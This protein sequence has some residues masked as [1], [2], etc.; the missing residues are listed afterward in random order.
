[1]NIAVGISGGVDSAVAA[2]ICKN[3]GHNVIGVIMK[4][5][6]ENS[7]YGDIDPTRHACYGPEEK[8]D[9]EDAVR[10]CKT[11]DIPLHIIDCVDAFSQKIL[12][13]FKKTYR[14][15]LTP[16]PCIFC[17]QQLK[18]GLL[19]ELLQE[20]QLPI[21][22]FATGHYARV[23]QSADGSV[24][25]LRASDKTKDQSYFLHRLT[26][27]QLSRTLF[28]L[29]ELSKMQVREIARSN[30]LHV[31]GKTESQD[32]YSGDYRNILKD[33]NETSFG[34]NIVDIEGNVLG[35]HDGIWNYTIGQRKGLG[36]AAGKP[37]YVIDIDPDKRSV[38]VGEKNLL[39]KTRVTLS[40]FHQ[41]EQLKPDLTCKIRSSSHMLDCHVIYD[42]SSNV[43]IEFDF[44][45]TGI[46]P[47]QSLVLYDND[48]VIGGGII[49]EGK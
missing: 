19:P 42:N 9:I 27:D 24:H 31:W 5:W 41:L 13:Y 16:N 10:V 48:I 4:I 23:Q 22:Y 25:L 14:Q 47:G 49:Q 6:D 8:E 39:E 44:P 46:C 21:D 20:Q 11:I 38:I 36:I 30:G 40:D 7:S 26:R 15:G 35:T 32:F 37:L 45:V 12:S 28:P 2:V 34:G 18:F 29:G 17:N 43:V 3:Q 33:E 1:M